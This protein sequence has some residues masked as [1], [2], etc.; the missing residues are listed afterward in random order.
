MLSLFSNTA[1][2][3]D[4]TFPQKINLPDNTQS[5]ARGSPEKGLVC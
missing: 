1:A 5:K 2:Q 4:M 3:T